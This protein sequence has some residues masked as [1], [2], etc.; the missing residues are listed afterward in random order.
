M[1]MASNFQSL[2]HW[3]TFFRG[4][5]T[6]IFQVVENSIHIA[7]QDHPAEFPGRCNQLITRFT[8][9]PQRKNEEKV[10]RIKDLLTA[11]WKE[12]VCF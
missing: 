12:Q 2:E 9:Y 8:D 3:R 6:D 10:M 5:T 11:N 4:A 1:Y 7:S